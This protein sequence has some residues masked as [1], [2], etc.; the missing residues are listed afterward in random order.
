MENKGP[1][2][3]NIKAIIAASLIQEKSDKNI[4]RN[5]HPVYGKPY[6]DLPAEPGVP[7]K[8]NKD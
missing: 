1:I 3:E 8:K 7:L 6:F 2:K 4:P 5:F